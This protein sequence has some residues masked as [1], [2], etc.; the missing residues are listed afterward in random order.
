MLR[1]NRDRVEMITALLDRQLLL[2]DS[3][4]RPASPSSETSDANLD[5]LNELRD[6]CTLTRD[7]VLTLAKEPAIWLRP[8]WRRA[9]KA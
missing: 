5:A 7:M 8:P 1:T 9:H 2:I 4:L 3:R 6:L